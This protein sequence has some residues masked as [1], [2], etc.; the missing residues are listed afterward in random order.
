M[1]ERKKVLY[2][3]TKGNFGGA[4]RYVFDLATHLPSDQFEVVVVYGQGETLGAKLGDTGIRTIQIP[5]LKRNVGIFSD[6]VAFVALMKII[7]KERPD[8]LHLSSS[9][10]GG[11]GV[12]AGRLLGVPKIIFTGHGWAFNEKR[13]FLTKLIIWKLYWW[14]I[15]LS[16]KTIAVSER[17]ADQILWMPFL[18]KK[19][20]VIYNGIEPF[21]LLDKNMARN[22][23]NP[24]ITEPVWIG[25]LSE[26]H[27]IKGLDFT[28]RAFAKLAKEHQN[29]AFIIVGAG[30]ERTRLEALASNL[31]VGGKVIFTGFVEN[32]RNCLKA[33]D[34]FT[35]TS[36][37]E[38]LPYTPLEAGIAELA[39][40]ASWVGG[41]PEIIVNEESGLLVDSKNIDELSS[42][43]SNLV[44]NPQLR[45]LLGK[46]LNETVKTKFTLKKMLENTIALY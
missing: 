43:L 46:N 12:V 23:L 29:V 17:T 3:I 10:A 35:L 14:I 41:I 24:N 9:K 27:P 5:S 2:F 22:K 32:A 15:M 28:V 21:E 31:D 45:T 39:V 36:R 25:T 26:L 7:R 20:T 30:E 6:I 19:I 37:S 1:P 42:A 16:H 33:F 44:I 38:A 13:S 18:K 34:I 4:Q 40:V 11:L 8:V